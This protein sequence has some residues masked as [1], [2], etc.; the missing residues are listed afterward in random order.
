MLGDVR[1]RISEPVIRS[2]N[3]SVMRDASATTRITP[4]MTVTKDRLI[5]TL[6]TVVIPKEKLMMGDISG[7]TIM[8]PMIVGALFAMRPN[9]AITVAS[10]NMKK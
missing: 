6:S 1:L 7:A 5:N 9:V 4:A 8:A 3:K 10:A 2:P